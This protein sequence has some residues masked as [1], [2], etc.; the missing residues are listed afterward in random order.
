[1]SPVLELAH[2]EYCDTLSQR[3]QCGSSVGIHMYMLQ[4]CVRGS[5][6]KQSKGTHVKDRATSCPGRLGSKQNITVY[7][8][9]RRSV[10]KH[11]Y[12]LDS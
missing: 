4:W 9:V 3:Q 1:M 8:H 5:R 11:K 7:T 6:K 2:S 10:Y 12:T